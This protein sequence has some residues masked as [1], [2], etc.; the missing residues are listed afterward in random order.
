MAEGKITVKEVLKVEK[1]AAAER[2][3]APPAPVRG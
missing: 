3:W 2:R 1:D